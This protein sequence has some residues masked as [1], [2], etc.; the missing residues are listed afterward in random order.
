M[1]SSGAGKEPWQGTEG[2]MAVYVREEVDRC[3]RAYA[4]KPSIVDENAGLE[5]HTAGG[6]YA[7]RQLFELV[8]NSA[9]ALR[10][11]AG[12]K[13]IQI[14]LDK[15]FLYC[16]DDGNPIGK[17]GIDALMGAYQSDKDP[18]MIGRFGLGFKSVLGVSDSPEFYSRSVS[19]RFDR[20]HAKERIRKVV[21][22]AGRYPV[23][24]TPEPID[25]C[26]QISRDRKLQKLMEW[27][28]N[29]VRL[30]LQAGKDGKLTRQIRDFPPEFLLVVDHVLWLQMKVGGIDREFVLRE[31]SR[32]EISIIDSGERFAADVKGALADGEKTT[33]WKRFK[34]KHKLSGAAKA[35]CI[36]EMK[37]VEIRW[38]ARL[39]RPASGKFWAFFPT[40]TP[41]LV[42]GVLNAHWKTNED[43]QNLLSGEYNDELIGAAAALIAENL[44][45]L[46]TDDDPARHLDMLSRQERDDLP[47]RATLRKR[48]FENLHGKAIVPDQ[49]GNL[50]AI[51]DVSHPPE[52]LM[53]GHKALECWASCPGRPSNWLH[54]RALNRNRRA[55]IRWLAG[56]RGVKSETV[57]VWLEALVHGKQCNS[58]AQASMAAIKTAAELGTSKGLGRIV[59]AANGKRLPPDDASLVLLP[60]GEEDGES[61]SVHPQLTADA[62]TF[63][64]LEKLGVNQP[65]PES[66]FRRA[67]ERIRM[68]GDTDLW[69][70]FWVA[71]RKLPESRFMDIL[72]EEERRHGRNIPF[73]VRTRAGKW[74]S[75]HQVLLPGRIAPGDGSRDDAVTV[76]SFHDPDREV[77]NLLSLSESPVEFNERYGYVQNSLGVGKGCNFPDFENKCKSEYRKQDL[78]ATPRPDLLIF[79]EE[80][81]DHVGPLGVL[82]GLS[83]EGRA[84]Y[85][86]ALLNIDAVFNKWIM[87]HQTQD[88]YPQMEC[89]S[90]ALHML[91]KYGRIR[92]DSGIVPLSAALGERPA[93]KDAQHW[94]LGHS[95]AARIKKAFDD[96]AD[97]EP[98]FHGVSEPVPL[99]DVWPGIESYCLPAKLR[100]CCLVRCERIDVAGDESGECVFRD[101]HVYLADAVDD[102][103]QQLRLVADRLPGFDLDDRQIGKILEGTTPHEVDER[104]DAIRACSTDAERLLNAVGEERLRAGLPRSLLDVLESEGEAP[105][106]GVD[107]AEAA[108][109]TWHTGALQHHRSELR[110]LDPPKQWAGSSRAVDFVKSL[111]FSPE[112]AGERSSKTKRDPFLEVEGPY[113]LRPLHDYQET[114]ARN[115]K[116]MLRSRGGTGRRGLV[117]MPTGSGKTRVAVQAIV[118]AIRD[119][120]LR[121]GVLWVADRDELCEQAVEA[122]RQV[123][124]SCGKE[125]KRLRISRMWGGNERPSPESELHV[126]VAT[127]QTLESRISGRPGE[128][129]FLKEFQLLVCDEAHRSIAPTFTSVMEAIG[130]TRY[131]KEHEPFLLGLTATPYRGHD[132]RETERLV[133]RYGERRLDMGAFASDDS[134]LVVQELQG[135]RVLAEVDPGVIEGAKESMY[136]EELEK[137]RAPKGDGYL[138]WLPQSVER[139]IANSAART[140]RIIES[141][142]EHIHRDWPTLVFATSVEHAQTVAA[143]LSRKGIQARSV[144]GE[145]EGTARRRIVDEFRDGKIKVLVNYGVFREGFD[146]PKT[147]AIIV[148]RPVYSPNLYFQMIGR[149]L[150]G[151]LNGGDEKC[152]IL[153]VRDNIDNFKGRLAFTE[154]D[155]LW[156]R[157][158]GFEEHAA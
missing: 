153:N 101:P 146:A 65:S 106:A 130:L 29:I 88:H 131:K 148:A 157:D 42:S 21:P 103:R 84:L 128:Y 53:D 75:W 34:R 120:Q 105:L 107:I 143:L 7:D 27:A 132:E 133:K 83:D 47:H 109:A 60:P 93:S 48:L 26:K 3:L 114:V 144:S 57:P 67:Y 95:N 121:G 96:L 145:T 80:R 124:A 118:E 22:N 74:R 117:S 30:P 37:E 79:D 90:F 49:D 102:D 94:L 81:I 12:A 110:Q 123:W 45:N 70:E 154:L 140:R 158:S 119:G 36:S 40:D 56:P 50:C 127:I 151:P 15:D 129:K 64:A 115:I 20:K 139:R 61:S 134:E 14:I 31:D 76:D 122:W 156:S 71:S 82:E 137:M 24:R 33:R 10:D 54:H 18:N 135:R 16:A 1:N 39:D 77:L 25:P 149:G 6:G 69:E 72:R 2:K 136:P 58:L 155:W 108:I 126:I 142:E 138:P 113:S 59:L 44:P 41:S 99:T 147:R 91:R 19:V 5:R 35:D 17:K 89:D 55:I 62:E 63:D 32:G 52:E 111:G 11:S 73:L 97:P 8:Q 100:E 92:T 112:W 86:D 23:L 85:T 104:R 51:D 9:D 68:D 98:E 150:R 13:R 141:Y 116:D 38:V 43:R 125:A 66:R 4:E 46:A 152:L 28:T 87:K 78:P